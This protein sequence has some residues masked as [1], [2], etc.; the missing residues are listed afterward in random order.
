M[1]MSHLVSRRT[2]GAL[3]FVASACTAFASPSWAQ[4]V[5]LN[6]SMGD[7]VLELDAEKAPK[8][9]ANFV[10]YVKAGHYN[11]VVFHRVIDG[12]MIQ[13]GGY[14]KNLAEKPTRNAIA[15]E[16]GNGLS[17]TRGT[18][19]M[20]RTNV[21]ESA[22]AQFYINVNDNLSLDKEQARDGN[23]YAVFG[24]VIS[25]MEVV[26]QIKAVETTQRSVFQNLPVKTILIVKATL[27]P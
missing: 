3:L 26:D 24:R 8:T 17:N 11:G 10:Q 4:K 18:I 13:T 16:S 19:A 25:G 22:R 23:G 21:P 27:E 5:K 12:F 15:L 20:A 1:S 2:L 7:I 14:D 9:V 6:T